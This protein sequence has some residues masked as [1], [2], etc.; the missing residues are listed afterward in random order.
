MNRPNGVVTLV[1]CPAASPANQT[2]VGSM[3]LPL[4]FF[5]SGLEF[6]PDGRLWAA[7]QGFPGSMEQ[8]LYQVNTSTG[9]MTQVGAPTGLASDEVLTDLAWNPVTHRLVGMATTTTGGLNSRLLSFDIHNGAVVSAANVTSN[10]TVLHVG[11]ACLP[12]GEYR[13]LDVYNDWVSKL[14]GNQAVMLG[15][16]LSINLA[17]NQGIGTDYQTGKMWYAAY[18]QMNPALGIGAPSLRTVNTTTGV[19]TLVG[20]LPGGSNALYTDVTVQPTVNS[21]PADTT[22]DHFVDDSDFVSFSSQY[23][24]LECGTPAMTGACSADFNFDGVVDDADFVI[25]SVAYDAL[26]CP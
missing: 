10:V 13:L 5:V 21:C 15:N 23:D 9:V 24:A 12:N 19:D 22:S 17:Y 16:V 25:F 7:V 20:S 4:T 26:V 6:T 8:G 3:N 11:L 18:Q 2:S 14:V 1:R